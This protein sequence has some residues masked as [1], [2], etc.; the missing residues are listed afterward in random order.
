VNLNPVANEDNTEIPLV[1]A[2][3]KNYP[4]PFNPETTIRY[5]LSNNGPVKIQIY[6]IKGQLIRN[7]VNENKKAGNYTV[8]WNGKDEQG[9][10]V[11]SGIYFYRMQSSKYSATQKMMLMK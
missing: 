2:L 11:S 10:S 1:T 5:S 7:L 8:I 6:N 9:K 3:Q 4:N